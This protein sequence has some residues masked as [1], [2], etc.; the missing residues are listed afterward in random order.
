MQAKCECYE[1]VANN[2]YVFRFEIP[3]N[4]INAFDKKPKAT[5]VTTK[6]IRYIEANAN[7]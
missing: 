4:A 7:D 2:S 1:D 3:K 5:E 6:L